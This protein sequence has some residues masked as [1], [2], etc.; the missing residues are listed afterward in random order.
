MKKLILA[1]V[2][3]LAFTGVS[4]GA[5]KKKDSVVDYPYNTTPATGDY[6]LLWDAGTN[7]T[8]QIS[9]LTL[10]ARWQAL[11]TK[12]TNFAALSNSA[13]VL[14]NDGSG[15]LSWGAGGSGSVATDSIWDAAG[16]LAVGSGANTATK[17]AKGTALQV[18][19]V[20]AGG[21]ALEW[22]AASGGGDAYLGAP[23]SFTELTATDFL[24][25]TGNANIADITLGTT[26][27]YTDDI[28]QTFNPGVTTA[29]IN[30]GSLA[31]NPSSLA[32][33]DVW[34]NSSTGAFMGRA[35]GSSFAFGSGTVTSVGFTGG[36]ISVATA[37]S[38]PAFTVAGTSGGIP[39]FSSS[40]AWA[41]SG[42]L[43]ANALVLGGGA[44]AA[45][46]TTTTGTGVV[47]ALGVN[48]GSAGAI[49]VNGG[50]GGT[51]SSLTGTNITGIPEGGLS[52]TD[53]TTNNATTAKHGFLKKLSNSATEYMDGTGN[54]STPAGGGGGSGLTYA[55]LSSVTS[56]TT[57]TLVT[58]Y[59]YGGTIASAATYSIVVPTGADNDEI[60]VKFQVTGVDTVVTFSGA[61]VYRVGQTS[62]LGATTL[63]FPIGY[64]EISLGKADSKWYML[65]SSAAGPEVFSFAISDETTAITTGTAKLT[66]RA[67]YA[68]TIT[69]VYAELNT[70]SSSGN[71]AFD[72]NK[73]GTTVLSTVLTVDASE[74]DSATA[75]TPAVISV[76]TFAAR[77]VFTF[78]IDTA[79]TG[80]KGAKI[81]IL[82]NR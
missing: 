82:Y 46:T 55:A 60:K 21:T 34:Y 25:V 2:S 47:T 79:G 30:F 38:T 56:G 3:C 44:G 57:S 78:D 64:N 65:D 18:L 39:Y 66:W 37:T 54:W 14:T 61:S 75:A 62:A 16:D 53:V 41:S 63:T 67:P 42:A 32:N 43:A 68:G 77:D 27:T 12:L 1:I 26:I 51:P 29:G 48:V 45:P 15:V 50:A 22:A 40:S 24:T 23:A 58:Q 33:G 35:G 49:V 73:N 28:K 13:G 4:H 17:L 8:Q 70:T 59:S 9:I 80:A 5:W 69:A 71:P 52:T 10:D 7:T 74:T 11:N 81:T 19:R 31:G 72:I 76:P 20:N 36:L 6:I